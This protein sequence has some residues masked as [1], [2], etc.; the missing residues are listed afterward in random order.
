[1]LCRRREACPPVDLMVAGYLGWKAPA[2]EIPI[3]IDR[4]KEDA[5]FAA[6]MGDFDSSRKRNFTATEVI[7]GR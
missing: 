7:G 1:M 3:K 5:D 4:A 6:V 2:R